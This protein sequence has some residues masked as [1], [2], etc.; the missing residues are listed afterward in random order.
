SACPVHASGRAFPVSSCPPSGSVPTGLAVDATI[1][2]TSWHLR[3]KVSRAGSGL[4]HPSARHHG[5]WISA[6]A[7]HFVSLGL[8]ACRLRTETGGKETP[9]EALPRPSH[10]TG[11][12]EQPVRSRRRA[13][14]IEG[15]HRHRRAVR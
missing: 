10:R 5:G 14:S 1:A 7:W 11:A 6:R 4:G 15:G 12:R 9:H 8:E 3:V 2:P 13:R